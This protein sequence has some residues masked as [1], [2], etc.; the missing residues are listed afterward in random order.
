MK[1]NIVTTNYQ[2][3]RGSDAEKQCQ[4]EFNPSNIHTYKAAF[5]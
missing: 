5:N 4:Q 1:K 3:A 2:L